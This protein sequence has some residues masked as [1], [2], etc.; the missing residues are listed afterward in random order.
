[1]KHKLLTAL[2]AILFSFTIAQVPQGINYQAI[3]RNASG[4]LLS[5]H[6]VTVRLTIH[7]NTPTGAIAYSQVDTASTNQYGLFTIV[8][9]GATGIPGG[10]SGISWESGPKYL[11]VEMDP[12]AGASFADMGTT[13]L[14]SVPYALHAETSAD[15]VWAK[16]GNEISP[17]ILSDQLVLGDYAVAADNYLKIRAAGGNQ[18]KSGIRL[19][20][21]SHEYGF[22]LIND[23]PTNGFYISHHF[24][25]SAGVKVLTIDGNNN[26]GIGTATPAA[27]LDIAGNIKITDGTEG[28]GKVLTSDANGLATWK[29]PVD[30]IYFLA[31]SDTNTVFPNLTF[32]QVPFQTVTANDGNGYDANTNIFTVPTAGLYH[33]DLNIVE[34]GGGGYAY[35]Y[36]NNTTR[37]STQAYLAN[38]GLLQ[39]M[40]LSSTL[41]LQ[42]GDLVKVQV[43]SF[44]VNHL[45]TYGSAGNYFSGYKVR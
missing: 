5:N 27:K 11:Q 45:V 29:T 10:F 19:Q 25:D 26:V 28:N 3:A 13:E 41:K 30:D 14:V 39:P 42:A 12:T 44:G 23:D 40:A 36:V 15:N 17:K 34:T 38:T 21:Y 37:A 33:F 43:Y 7:A 18:Y 24:A 20:A 6:Q 32:T 22:D 9:G 4:N 2:S 35:L 8:I 1:M 31:T 16:Y